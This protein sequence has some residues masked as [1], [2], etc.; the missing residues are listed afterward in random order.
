M[1]SHKIHWCVSRIAIV[2]REKGQ[3]LWPWPKANNM[4][5]VQLFYDLRR[6]A[7]LGPEEQRKNTMD[8][9]WVTP[10]WLPCPMIIIMNLWCVC[11]LTTETTFFHSSGGRAGRDLGLKWIPWCGGKWMDECRIMGLATPFR[12]ALG[13]LRHQLESGTGEV[14]SFKCFN[15]VMIIKVMN[16]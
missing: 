5:G 2:R 16:L 8:F 7:W 10:N 3:V 4:D 13:V 15:V 12:I 14:T 1:Q 9:N 6:D 11:F